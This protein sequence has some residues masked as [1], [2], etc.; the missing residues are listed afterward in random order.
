[1]RILL[2]LGLLAVAC[3]AFA[4]GA[5]PQTA[6]TN[7]TLTIADY[8]FVQWDD[9]SG[10]VLD[11]YDLGGGQFEAYNAWT[12]KCDYTAG[13]N[14]AATLSLSV[15][16]GLPGVVTSGLGWALGNASDPV[17]AG[18]PFTTGKVNIKTTGITLNDAPGNYSAVATLS[19]SI[20]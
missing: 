9:A 20:P 15:G 12:S 19:I 3:S 14:K 8:C 18:T 2:T 17:L 16:A 10:I 1:M 7:V 5:S 13:A 11:L 6:A 4:G